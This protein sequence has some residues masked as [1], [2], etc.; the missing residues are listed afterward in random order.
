MDALM[1]S[2]NLRA[3]VVRGLLL[4]VNLRREDERVHAGTPW[5]SP[6]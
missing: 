5:G 1:M 3:M 4:R 2:K 6:G